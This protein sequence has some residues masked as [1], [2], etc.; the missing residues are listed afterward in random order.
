[1]NNATIQNN[2]EWPEIKYKLVEL[3]ADT[4]SYATDTFEYLYAFISFGMISQK[5]TMS[6]GH[7]EEIKKWHKDYEERKKSMDNA[8]VE[9]EK[10]AISDS[11][12][13]MNGYVYEIEKMIRNIRKKEREEILR[14]IYL[15]ISDIE[16]EVK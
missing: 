12:K 1:M 4:P 14:Y 16:S 11:E 13:Q 6:E 10:V 9:T 7:E 2:L 5:F 8:N 3:I 15:L